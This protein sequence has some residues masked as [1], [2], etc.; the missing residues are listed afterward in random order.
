MII[1]N[2]AR[3]QRGRSDRLLRREAVKKRRQAGEAGVRDQN[4]AR[5]SG[6]RIEIRLDAWRSEVIG[7]RRGEYR[8]FRPTK[9]V[10]TSL[11][12]AA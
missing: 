2:M 6:C 7:D 9:S 11:D 10:E 12:A 8:C 5:P 3:G 1:D 4:V